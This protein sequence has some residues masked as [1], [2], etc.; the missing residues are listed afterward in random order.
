VWWLAPIIALGLVGLAVMPRGWRLASLAVGFNLAFA[1]AMSVYVF[2]LDGYTNNGTTRWQNRT[3][4]AHG[5]YLATMLLTAI[6][7]ALFGLAARRSRGVVVG[8]TL[9]AVSG[10]VDLI[11]GYALLLV[12]DNN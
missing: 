6:W 2:G 7:I 4:V 9:V 10:A 3:A 12:F 1:A 8:P 5:L 11:L